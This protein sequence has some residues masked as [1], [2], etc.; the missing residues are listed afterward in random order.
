MLDP[1]DV[2]YFKLAVGSNVKY[3]SPGDICVRCPVCGDSKYSKNKARLHLYSKGNRTLVNCFNECSVRNKTMYRFLRDHYPALL[4]NYRQEKFRNNL[5]TLASQNT[6]E[7]EKY[8][9]TGDFDLSDL[10]DISEPEEPENRP[11]VLFSPTFFKKSDKPYQ[12]LESRG[13]KWSPTFGE[14]Y[15]GV[16]VTVDNKNFPIEGYVVIPFYCGSECYGFYSRSMREHKFYTYMPEANTDFKLWNYYN[17][18][19]TKAVYVFEGIFDAMSV[20]QSG[21]TNV[22]A[23]CGATPPDSLLEGLECVMCFDNDS[24][25]KKN[26]LK[27]AQKGYKVLVYPESVRE[28]DF[29]EMLLHGR[30]IC[31]ILNN[32]YSGIM[33]QVKI[34]AVM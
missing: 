12:Y 25:G 31:D 23:C 3:E 9:L 11:K 13:L 29:N 34:S 6:A 7:L 19:R 21:I 22:V 8:D 30:D 1:V 27:Y 28:K 18:D 2:R 20:F 4:E 32:V 24:T 14:F 5:S 10:A 16:N 33:A 15:E 26:A 17:I